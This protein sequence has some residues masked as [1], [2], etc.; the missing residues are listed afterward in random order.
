[1]ARKQKKDLTSLRFHLEVNRDGTDKNGPVTIG[2]TSPF[3]VNV[4]RAWFLDE[5][6]IQSAAVV[7]DGLGGFVVVV[8]F[9][10]KGSWLLE[11]YTTSNRGR[12]VAIFA[13]FNEPRWIA[14]PKIGKTISNGTFAFTPDATREEAER[15]VRGLNNVAR[16]VAKGRR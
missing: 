2:R 14:A 7:D 13:A 12:C 4:E 16:L 8:Q 10:R 15:L 6:Q 5:Q 1:M 3:V 11:Q 9:E